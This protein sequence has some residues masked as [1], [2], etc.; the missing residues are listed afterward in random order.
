MRERGKRRD[1]ERE[2][3]GK[4]TSSDIRVTRPWCLGI[5]AHVCSLEIASKVNVTYDQH[6]AASGSH[7]LPVHISRGARSARFPAVGFPTPFDSDKIRVYV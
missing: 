2:R 3:E 4:V 5:A 7:T 6:Y 1:R